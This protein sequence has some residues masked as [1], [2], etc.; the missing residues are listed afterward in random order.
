MWRTEQE[1]NNQESLDLINSLNSLKCEDD[2]NNY[3]DNEAK[4]DCQ[5]DNIIN[6]TEPQQKRFYNNRN[7]N[8]QV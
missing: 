7:N 8:Y 2:N 6:K 1:L 5:F 3:Y 4:Y